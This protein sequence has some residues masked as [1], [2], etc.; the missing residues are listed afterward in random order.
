M[1][2]YIYNFIVDILFPLRCIGC[3]KSDFYICDECIDKIPEPNHEKLEEIEACFDY[4]HPLIKKAIWDLKYYNKKHAS[5][6]LGKQLGIYMYEEISELRQIYRGQKF[7]IIP[8]PLSK[9]RFRER[10][11]NQAEY[12][13]HAFAQSFHEDI[14][15]INTNIVLKTR[16]TGHQARIHNKKIRLKNI[17]GAFILNKNINLN[18]RIVFVLD[19]VTTT[20]ATL[21]EIIKILKKAGAREVRGIAVAH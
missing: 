20:G 16:D 18:N 12:L 19:D 1:L 9:E 14:F 3:K 8:V 11:Y 17:I 10:G 13:A 15:E 4:Q 7:I 2:S 6:A 5:V 21:T